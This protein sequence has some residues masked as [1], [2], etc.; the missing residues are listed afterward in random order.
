MSLILSRNSLAD[1]SRNL[2]YLFLLLLLL[3]TF[4]N[5]LKPLP[6]MRSTR[7]FIQSSSSS[8]RALFSHAFVRKFLVPGI[9]QNWACCLH[10]PTPFAFCTYY[11][12][13]V[14]IPHSGDANSWPIHDA[15][16]ARVLIFNASQPYGNSIIRPKKKYKR[17]RNKLAGKCDSMPQ[18]GR[19][20]RDSEWA[21]I[22][23]GNGIAA[24]TTIPTG[25]FF[26]LRRHLRC[27]RVY[28][29]TLRGVSLWN[30]NGI[31]IHKINRAVISEPHSSR[32]PTF[33]NS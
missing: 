11:R 25:T 2:Y 1:P 15:L 24:N 33:T 19:A 26:G 21:A 6:R 9:P 30:V 5:Y 13:S 14:C 4:K 3:L 12:D 10:P 17:N 27:L 23:F 32:T 29:F 8:L 22:G 7:I 18:V 20:E 16:P 28:F 31:F